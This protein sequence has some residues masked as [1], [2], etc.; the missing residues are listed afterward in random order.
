[1]NEGGLLLA[2]LRASAGCEEDFPEYSVFR[3]HTRALLR[4]YFARTTQKGRM[5][6]IWTN[7]M[8]RSRISHYKTATLEDDTIFVHDLERC[9]AREFAEEELKLLALTVFLDTRSRKPLP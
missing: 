8:S 2:G 4:H 9:L 6:S 1:M 3:R 5:P 7:S